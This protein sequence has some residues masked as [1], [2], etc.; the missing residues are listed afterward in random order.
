MLSSIR[1]ILT[2]RAKVEVGD[3]PV[4]FVGVGAY[5]LDVDVAAYVKTAN[6]DEFLVIQQELLLAMLQAIEQAGTAL[7]VPFQESFAMQKQS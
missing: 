3:M 5:S 6:Y 4:R 2:S 1:G 7:A